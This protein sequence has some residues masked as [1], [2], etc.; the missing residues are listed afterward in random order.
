MSS[1]FASKRA[2]FVTLATSADASASVWNLCCVHSY[3][4]VHAIL[5]RV[6]SSSTEKGDRES[7]TGVDDAAHRSLRHF[8]LSLDSHS[9]VAFE[10]SFSLSLS[11]R[12]GVAFHDIRVIACE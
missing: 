6:N 5:V 12:S 2:P 1:T 4:R 8:S 7:V 10:E 3:A 11:S 9:I